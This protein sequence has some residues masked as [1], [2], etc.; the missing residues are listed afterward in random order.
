MFD[1]LLFQDFFGY[2]T[3]LLRIP[4][5]PQGSRGS[6]GA[7]RKC[8]NYPRAPQVPT[9]T[10]R[11]FVVSV[12][13]PGVPQ[14][15][16]G[17]FWGLLL[18]PEVYRITLG[19]SQ[20]PFGSCGICLLHAFDP[21]APRGSSGGIGGD[22]RSSWPAR[23]GRAVE[24][25]CGHPTARTSAC[26]SSSFSVLVLGFCTSN[27]IITFLYINSAICNH[28]RGRDPRFRDPQGI[29]VNIGGALIDYCCRAAFNGCSLA[30]DHS[31]DCDFTIMVIDDLVSVTNPGLVDV[32][33]SIG[34]C[35]DSSIDFSHL[36]ICTFIH[37]PAFA[38]S[39]FC[40][41][42]ILN[43]EYCSV[44]VDF[45][46]V[47]ALS[48][49]SSACGWCLM[50]FPWVC[51]VCS[52][53]T[54]FS[55]FHLPSTLSHFSACACFCFRVYQ[56]CSVCQSGLLSVCPSACP[57]LCQCVSQCVS[58]SVGQSAYPS[59]SPSV[60]SVSQCA[61]L[62]FCRA[63]F[64]HCLSVGSHVCQSVCQSLCES[65]CQSLCESGCQSCC[66]CFC[67][68][69]ACFCPCCV[70]PFPCVCS[71]CCPSVR[72]SG[73]PSSSRCPRRDVCLSASPCADLSPCQSC[74]VS[75]VSSVQSFFLLPLPLLVAQEYKAQT[76]EEQIGH[77]KP[78]CIC[79]TVICCD[80]ISGGKFNRHR[81]PLGSCAIH[82]F[83][84][85]LG[86]ARGRRSVSDVGHAIRKANGRTRPDSVWASREL[87]LRKRRMV[88]PLVKFAGRIAGLKSLTQFQPCADG[89]TLGPRAVLT[90]SQIQVSNS[91][92]GLRAVGRFRRS[93]QPL[94]NF[95]PGLPAR[96][97]IGASQHPPAGQ[98][99]GVSLGKRVPKSHGGERKQPPGRGC[100]SAVRI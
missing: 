32:I 91:N 21:G 59:P 65:V 40:Q 68:C 18:L 58:Q 2:P 55:C 57:S 28:L 9:G 79:Y 27:V 56:S 23:S 60:C 66:A 64:S 46:S 92:G 88:P 87:D 89:G 29:H 7:R 70:C 75:F 52:S 17:R 98:F 84:Y 45:V 14:V 3:I 35:F 49:C 74:S 47:C 43:T 22:W 82:P 38:V 12:S 51:H 44:S 36:D 41:P 85:A 77:C 67:P 30:T 99:G 39:R 13:D 1:C 31:N 5:A 71:S 83:A 26:T 33:I 93:E 53:P 61:C 81:G 8:L 24:I 4:G 37:V 72:L 48:S 42:L 16:L 86:P 73:C 80:T 90:G 25:D 97:A 96:R 6:L 11:T 100:W 10:L 19:G 95:S 20:G 54:A 78:C 63:C 15:P 94:F 69:Y 62:S 34:V 50:G 76:S